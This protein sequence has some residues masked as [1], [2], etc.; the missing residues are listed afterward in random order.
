M[1]FTPCGRPIRWT[2]YLDCRLGGGAIRYGNASSFGEAMNDK[3][4]E[5]PITCDGCGKHGYWWTD[6]DDDTYQSDFSTYD[7]WELCDDCMMEINS[8]EETKHREEKE[9]A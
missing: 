1:V 8:E 7:E 4:R 9:A 6:P 5:H 3:Y 2:P